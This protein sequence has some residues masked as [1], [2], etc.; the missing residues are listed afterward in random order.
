MTCGEKRSGQDG[1]ERQKRLTAI[2][3]P[4]D[5]FD[6]SDNQLIMAEAKRCLAFLRGSPF[7]RAGDGVA[8]AFARGE[9]R[10]FARG[11]EELRSRLRIAAFALLP[12]AD[13]E[14]SERDQ[15]HFVALR[16]G[17][18]YAIEHEIDDLARLA[19]RE[20]GFFGN[21]VDEFG[22]C[23]RIKLQQRRDGGL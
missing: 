6:E 13:D 19:L 11:D 12:L 10:N 9:R 15:L 4:A 7:L 5:H 21:R 8:Q 18:S 3:L 17:V 1:C 22:F 23:Q 20:F 14:T 2:H 16:E